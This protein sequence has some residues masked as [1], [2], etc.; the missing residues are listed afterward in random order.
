MKTNKV[1]YIGNKDTP[2]IFNDIAIKTDTDLDLFYGVTASKSD[3]IAKAISEKWLMIIIN[4]DEVIAEQESIDEIIKSIAQGTS[5]KLIVMAQ[6]Y[7]PNSKVVI[8]AAKSG[9]K[10]FMLATDA[11]TN[12]EIYVN[13]LAGVKNVYDIVDISLLHT[14]KIIENGAT[15][16]TAIKDFKSKTISVGGCMSRIG[17]T[18]V[19]IQLVKYFMVN[20]KTACYVDYSDTD[21]IE[22]CK[23]FYGGSDDKEHH[24]YVLGDIDIYY[25][26]TPEYLQDIYQ[27]NYDFIVFDVG[28][29][30]V[31]SSKQTV[32]LEKDYRLLCAGCKPQEYKA[33]YSLLENLYN[34]NISYLYFAV[35]QDNKEFIESDWNKSNKKGY[36]FPFLDDCFYMEDASSAIFDDIFEEVMPQKEVI[37]EDVTE[38]HKKGRFKKKK[39][40]KK[41]GK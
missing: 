11:T 2:F 33:L 29:I 15:N 27:H 35:P 37:T 13:T 21:F 3:I 28:N 10:Y 20:G 38:P 18:T 23:E 8:N 19:A 4:V 41:G 31:H 12:K 9:V 26:V 6:G 40:N 5:S 16:L 22:L 17:T 34:T 36:F 24:R 32:F 14:K 25:D 39:T 30:S 7:N 1:L